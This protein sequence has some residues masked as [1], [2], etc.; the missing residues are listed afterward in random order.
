MK[1]ASYRGGRDGQ[2][3]VVSRDLKTAVAADKGWT[4]L[5]SALDAWAES[6][7]YL[8]TLYEA[9]N[10]HTAPGVQPFDIARCTAPLPRA[11]S[12][13]DGSVFLNHVRLM[14]KSVG[15]EMPEEMAS[16]PLMYQGGSDTFLGPLDDITVA[17][18]DSWGVDLEAELAVITAD[19][20]MATKPEDALQHVCLVAL[21]ND[22]SLRLLQPREMAT[23]FGV[24]ISKPSTAFAPVVVTPDELGEA[25]QG[26]RVNLPMLSFR[27]GEPFGRPS[28]GVGM[29]YSFGDL[30]A[31]AATTRALSAG[32][33]VGSGTVSNAQPVETAAIADGGVGFSCISEARAVET[34]CH[35]APR[36]PF[37]HF[38]DRVRIEMLDAAGETI[39]GAIDQTVRKLD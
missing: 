7:P 19:V 28:A 26:G 3:M 36:T 34:I 17:E 37:L 29:D 24:L 20:P 38:G 32:A 2:L 11:Y 1:L 14:L 22:V 15:R 21:L 5:Q 33:V 27:N 12:W 35:G 4:T 8:S 31:H 39:F 13:T 18:D 23:G 9:L 6:A 10:A 30:I 16:R 25:W